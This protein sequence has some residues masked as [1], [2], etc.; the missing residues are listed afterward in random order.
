MIMITIFLDPTNQTRAQKDISSHIEK[1]SHPRPKNPLKKSISSPPKA[2]N[3]QPAPTS[4]QSTASQPIESSAILRKEPPSVSRPIP[5][6]T[7][8]ATSVIIP[9]TARKDTLPTADAQERGQ[10]GESQPPF[11]DQQLRKPEALK[12]GAQS[13]REKFSSFRPRGQTIS[14]YPV[15]R[16]SPIDGK[17]S[18]GQSENWLK[19]SLNPY[20]VF[21]QFFYSPFI[22]NSDCERPILLSSG[23]VS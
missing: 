18:T 23:E 10:T 5:Q 3:P 1:T 22:R 6:S 2:E 8:R 13:F 15:S 19:S 17:E 20:F 14:T 7:E 16:K 21:L 12:T 9:S 11:R 4:S